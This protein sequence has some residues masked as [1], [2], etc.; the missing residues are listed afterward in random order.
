MALQGIERIALGLA[1]TAAVLTSCGTRVGSPA[2]TGTVEREGMSRLRSIDDFFYPATIEGSSTGSPSR[3]RQI[4]EFFYPASPV[5]AE[6][7]RG[8]P[9]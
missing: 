1:F 9:C 4:D 5:V 8:K 2:T 3:L 7:C 6:N